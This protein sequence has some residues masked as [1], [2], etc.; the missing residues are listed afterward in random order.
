MNFNVSSQCN[1]TVTA[2][3]FCHRANGQRSGE[4]KFMVYRESANTTGVYN[5]VPNSLYTLTED[6]IY[7][8]E[9]MKD[10]FVCRNIS[11]NTSQQFQILQNDVISTCMT[12]NNASLNIIS[13]SR[14]G[15]R[16]EQYLYRFRG[17]GSCI[18][19]RLGTILHSNNA[20]RIG[21]N[22]QL[23]LYATISKFEADTQSDYL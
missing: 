4:I 2:W 14:N 10:E 19:E 11:L 15:N 22:I 17:Y 5:L 13:R 7:D 8:Y 12:E 16:K 18:N 1:G 6:T 3:N 20:N 9:H 23:H 21:I